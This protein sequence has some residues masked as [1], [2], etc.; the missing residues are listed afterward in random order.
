[1]TKSTPTFYVFHGDDDVS[2]EAAVEKMRAEMFASPNG[3]F[4]TVQFEG[5]AVSAGEVLGA[6][7]AYPFLAE[8]RMVIVK[9]LLAQLARKGAG[10]TGKK[11][12]ELLLTQLPELPDYARLIF[13]ERGEL[14]DSHKVLQLAQSH[15]RGFVRRFAGMDEAQGTQWLIKRAQDEYGAQIAPNAARALA[16]VTVSDKMMDVRRAENELIKLIS[17]IGAGEDGKPLRPISEDDVALLTPY[18]AE[19]NI[20]A[21]VEALAGGRGKDA[22][23][24]LNRLLEEK[25]NDV[26]S[27][28]GMIIRQFRLLLLVKEHLTTGGTPGNIGAALNIRFGADKLATQSRGFSLEQLESVYRRLLDYDWQIKTGR[29][30]PELAL[31][32]F[33]ASMTR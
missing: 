21:M 9:G 7:Q 11:G 23:T 22:L 24:M 15:E 6:A 2:I 26:F 31:D 29:I 1:M 25:D 10:E 27:V 20:F 12:I 4:N 18:A 5:D 3:E 14:S 17:Y 8:K 33:I 28:F 19:A 13:R 16:L 30:A 32:L